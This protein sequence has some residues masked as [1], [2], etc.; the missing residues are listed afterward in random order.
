MTPPGPAP[1]KAADFELAERHQSIVPR[2]SSLEHTLSTIVG[3]WD[4]RRA[5]AL[6]WAIIV[7][8]AVEIVLSLLR[9]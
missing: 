2:I 9:H 7:L 8:I 1:K 3:V 5:R 4:V 6:E